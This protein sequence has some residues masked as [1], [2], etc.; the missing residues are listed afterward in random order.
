MREEMK[1][2]ANIIHKVL[3][4]TLEDI[5][6]VIGLSWGLDQ[7]R[8]GTELTMAYQVDLSE[9]MHGLALSWT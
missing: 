6:A 5:L 8:S 7:K 9:A 3:E 1:D 4:K 2:Y